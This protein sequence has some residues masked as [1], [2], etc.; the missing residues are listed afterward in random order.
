MK[1]FCSPDRRKATNASYDRMIK[2]VIKKF[3]LYLKDVF[4]KSLID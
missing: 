1:Q 3:E 2:C 4:L